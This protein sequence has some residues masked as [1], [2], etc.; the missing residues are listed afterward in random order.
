MDPNVALDV[1]SYSPPPAAAPAGAEQAPIVLPP[2][3]APGAVPVPAFAGN[4]AGTEQTLA[5][6][7]AAIDGG[8]VP[9]ET[10]SA[11]P[12]AAAFPPLAEGET[13]LPAEVAYLPQT[14]PAAPALAAATA[15]PALGAPAS[16]LDAQMASIG[17]VPAE[18]DAATAAP[19][20]APRPVT[21]EAAPAAQEAPVDVAMLEQ[22]Q[23][24]SSGQFIE[25][26]PPA[27]DQPEPPKK[28]TL[29]SSLFGSRP[30]PPKPIVD[31][32]PAKPLIAQQKKTVVEKSEAQPIVEVS[33]PPPRPV[34]MA[35]LGAS[36]SLPGVR[37][38]ALFEIKRKS[39]IDDDS[40]VDLHEDEDGGS[41]QLA[42]AAGLARLAPNGLLK[43]TDRV[44]V[45]CLK[46]SLVRV[47]KTIEKHYGR[48]IVVTSGYRS[49]SHNRRARG[50]KNS[51][52]MFCAAADIQVEG[53]AKWDLANYARSMPGRGGVG[54][55]CNTDSVH[56]DVGPERDWNW[57]CRRRK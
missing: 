43:Q 35:S 26:A 7:A 39:G 51:L 1:P 57:R 22:P 56:V 24:A 3:S 10:A 28:K 23:P 21:A 11:Q 34:V 6:S 9:V 48:P 47:L 50:A 41:F 54:T 33:N 20:P 18:G 29:F 16:T 38:T 49:P 45:A 31:N 12:D 5:S 53:V 32:G 52:H 4:P 55:Y 44:D 46:P 25:N 37:Q 40:D 2:P 8:T 13:P 27:E 36:D 19:V 14:N 30:S 42:S 17:G 15:E